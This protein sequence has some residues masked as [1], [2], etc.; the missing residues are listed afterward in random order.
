[1]RLIAPALLLVLGVAA[2]DGSDKGA[3]VT[4]DMTD[5]NKAGGNRSDLTLDV[6]GFSGKLSLPGIKM[7]GDTVSLN[8]VKL[9][10][11]STISAMNVNAKGSGGDDSEGD[12]D[13]VVNIRF[14]SPAAP[15][16][17]RD[18]F[19]ERLAKAD[20]DL[21]RQGDGLVG[22]DEEGKQFRL[23]LLPAAGGHTTGEIVIGG[24]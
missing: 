4:I 2:C 19:A 16:V 8:G 9:Y 7:G 11:G 17:V 6:P 24:K 23:T 14:D 12:D 20:F 10:P 21:T 13:D 15:A 18:W 22:T 5:G 1:M 3:G